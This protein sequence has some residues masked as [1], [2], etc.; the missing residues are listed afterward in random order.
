MRL[1]LAEKG[2]KMRTKS[3]V[4]ALA[5]VIALGGAGAAEENAAAARY[6]VKFCSPYKP[7]Q[8]FSVKVRSNLA[9]S[10]VVKIAGTVANSTSESGNVVFEGVETVLQVDAHG[11]KIAKEV[12]V[13]K[14]VRTSG[15]NSEVVI[16]ENGKLTV[17]RTKE[18]V[19][20]KL[21]GE[22]VSDDLRKTLQDVTPDITTETEDEDEVYGAKEPKAV[23][24]SWEPNLDL[25]LKQANDVGFDI[26][27][28]EDVSGK[29]TLTGIEKLPGGGE[30]LALK[31]AVEAKA[32]SGKEISGSKISA[33]GFKSEL[34]MLCPV[35]GSVQP[36]KKDMHLQVAFDTE[37]DGG[38]AGKVEISVR[39]ELKLAEE[40]AEL[41]AAT[42]A[43]AGKA[44]SHDMPKDAGA[45]KADG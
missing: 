42:P 30:A 37:S 36:V 25:V 20:F 1:P 26:C 34:A 21:N 24:D 41:S 12:I 16:P 45:V 5:C 31:A 4:A 10:N 38:G 8:R 33:G 17:T 13:K 14:C 2:R 22:R 3:V 28:R 19:D 11:R 29:V 9:T 27:K 32:D 35:G 15:G 23:G 39:L 18:G 7:G 43:D 40:R 44:A 6:P